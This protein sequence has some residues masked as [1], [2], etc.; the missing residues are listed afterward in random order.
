MIGKAH[1]TDLRLEDISVSGTHCHIKYSDNEF[2]LVDDESKFGTLIELKGPL[3]IG[4]QRN[5]VQVGRTIFSF[6]LKNVKA[7]NKDIQYELEK[8]LLMGNEKEVEY[9]K[10][11]IL[12]KINENKE[13]LAELNN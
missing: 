5:V 12:K 2:L 9:D 6:V 8:E 10:T 7:S 3:R 13:R 11:R 1:Q 4:F